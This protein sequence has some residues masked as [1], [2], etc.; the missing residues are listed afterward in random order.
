[1][2]CVRMDSHLVLQI[3][4]SAHCTI[5][6]ATKKDACSIPFDPIPLVETPGGILGCT[7]R[8]GRW[9]RAGAGVRCLVIGMHVLRSEKKKKLLAAAAAEAKNTLRQ[10]GE[11]LIWRGYGWP[12]TR[13]HRHE[14]AQ[15]QNMDYTRRRRWENILV[16]GNGNGLPHAGLEPRKVAHRQG[17]GASTFR[18][19]NIHLQQF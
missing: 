18:T 4:R 8:W 6:I 3:M 5:T 7:C 13:N 19:I 2:P 15:Q 14:R 17:S 1:M 9:D 10:G 16:G 12:A 11:V